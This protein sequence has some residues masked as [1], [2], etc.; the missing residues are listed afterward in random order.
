MK[1]RIHCPFRAAA[2]VVV[3]PIII[4]VNAVAQ[5]PQA[6][7][8]KP[9][10]LLSIDLNRAAVVEK[11][12]ASWGKELPAAQLGAFKD[13][14]MALRADQLLAANLAGTFDGVLEVLDDRLNLRSSEQRAHRPIISVEQAQHYNIR[15]AH[16]LERYERSAQ[17]LAPAQ[18][19]AKAVG[20]PSFDLVYTPLPPCNLM[21]T[22]PGV[23]PA[24]PVGGPALA[25]GYAARVVQVTGRCGVPLGA[26]AVASLFTVENIPSSGGVVFAGIAGGTAGAVAS[27]SAPTS[28]ASG[29]SIVSLSS[30]GALQLQSAGVTHIKVDITGYFIP[31][32]RNGN[33][34]RIFNGNGLTPTVVNGTYANVS[35]GIASTIAGGGFATSATGCVDLPAGG[36][37]SCANIAE[38][39]YT[40]IGGGYAHEISSAGYTATIAGGEGNTVK[41]PG[42]AIGGGFQNSVYGGNSAIAGGYQNFAGG[43]ASTVGGGSGNVATGVASTIPGGRANAATGD[44]SFA[45]GRRAKAQRAGQFVWA[46]S[47]NIDFDPQALGS[48]SSNNANTFQARATGGVQFVTG[49]NAG[50]AVTHSCY[51]LPSSAGWN[52][53]SDRNVKE[54]FTNVSPKAVLAKLM[55][56]P[57]S[58]WSYIGS[59]A[60]QMGPMAQDFHAAFGLSGSDKSINNIDAQGVAFAA[61]QGLNQKVSAELKRKDAKVVALERELAAIKKK[62]GM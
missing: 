2:L 24:P 31:A 5:T 8:T 4:A 6:F 43:N 21:D 42:G 53:S 57:V 51:M 44:D 22:R 36:T 52:C 14:L 18:D 7:A 20:E 33:G 15:N 29:S 62:L 38:A 34:L 47:I 1:L 28:Y 32:N 48:F 13:K 17:T 16:D 9:D 11:I 50:G 56:V 60:L 25:G 55:T 3:V 30:A 61:I 58:T 54:A 37:R 59:K 27:W 46:D 49:V 35:T 39:D 45:A 26:L 41:A 19:L 40:T 12:T 10:A 23:S